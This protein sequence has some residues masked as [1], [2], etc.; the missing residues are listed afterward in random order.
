MALTLRH[1]TAA[2]FAARLR[3]AYRDGDRTLRVRIA[4]F[5]LA[6]LTTGDITDAQMRAVFGL[7]VAQWSAL[8]TRMQALVTADA[9]LANSVG[10]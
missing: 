7:T 9:A 3:A 10:E 6:R 4:R 2:E 5:V 8:K 1:Q